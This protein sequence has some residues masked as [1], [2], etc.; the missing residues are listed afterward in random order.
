MDSRRV[1]LRPVGLS[2]QAVAGWGLPGGAREEGVP[3]GAQAGGWGW[4]DRRMGRQGQL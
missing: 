4:T 2:L 1:R 3:C